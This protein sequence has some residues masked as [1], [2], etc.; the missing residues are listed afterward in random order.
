MKPI[1]GI[2]MRTSKTESDN[3]VDLVYI[4]IIDAIIKSGGLPIGIPSA[5]PEKYLN[6]CQGFILEGGDDITD[7]NL[8]LLKK[9][10][11][12]DIPVLG[13]CLGMQEMAYLENGEISDIDNHKIKGT[14]K[15]IIDKKSFLYKILNCE[16]L[17]VN[18]RHKSAVLKTDLFPSSRSTDGIIESIEDPQKKFYIGLQWHP[19]NLY[20]CDI[21]AKRIFDYFIKACQKN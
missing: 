18:S 19:E 20:N 17:T 10:K 14:H 9:L 3:K 11:D 21:F 8:K 4:S 13:I 12:K 15:V 1:I 5:Y 2:I 6:L 16:E 7:I